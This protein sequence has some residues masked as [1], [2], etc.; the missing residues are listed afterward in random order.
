MMRVTYTTFLVWNELVLEDRLAQRAERS[1]RRLDSTAYVVLVA[2]VAVDTRTEV[3]EAVRESHERTLLV[4]RH[5]RRIFGGDDVV[6]VRRIVHALGL[7]CL[8][9]GAHVHQQAEPLEVRMDDRHARFQLISR[10]KEEG[11]VVVVL[12]ATQLNAPL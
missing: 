5:R 3:L 9:G 4:R 1:R 2:Q 10:G 11:A 6:A 7:R 12:N 8:I